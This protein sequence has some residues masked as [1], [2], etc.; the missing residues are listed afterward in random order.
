MYM[1][2]AALP[3]PPGILLASRIVVSVWGLTLGHPL[4][5]AVRE[6]IHDLTRP[7]LSDIGESRLMS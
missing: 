3:S 1:K 5:A 7:G 6:T 2:G 4:V